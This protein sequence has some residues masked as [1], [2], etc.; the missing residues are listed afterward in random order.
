MRPN[1][2]FVAQ[3]IRSLQTMLRVIFADQGKQVLLIPDGIYGNQTL[4]AVSAFQQS[5]GLPV[6]GITDQQT[7]EAVVEAFGPA[8]IRTGAAQPIQIIL[9]PGE[10]IRKEQ[11]HPIVLLAQ[12]MLTQLADAY[13]STNPPKLSGVLDL[14]TSQSLEGFQTLS[15]LP[16]TGEL[17][18]I[19]WKHL[20]LQYPL[21]SNLHRR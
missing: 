7:W 10:I 3:P 8:N 19:T 14:P 1:A 16:A 4:A 12:S 6:T 15:G 18:K 2:S 5:C 13:Q 20:A 9:N 17:D 11:Q 21:A